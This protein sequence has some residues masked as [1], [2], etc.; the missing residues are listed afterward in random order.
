MIS[1]TAK[2]GLTAVLR[3][4]LTGVEV[5]RV[6]VDVDGNFEF[7]AS[8]TALYSLGFPNALLLE[9]V[10]ESG[11]GVSSD[12]VEVTIDATVP[13]GPILGRSLDD[14]A[15][16]GDGP[17]LETRQLR[18]GS[19]KL[20][21]NN[22]DKIEGRFD[23]ADTDPGSTVT[24]YDASDPS[25]VLGTG[26]V[27]T[28]GRFEVD[29]VPPLPHGGQAV[30][31]VSEP[32]GNSSNFDVEIDLAAPTIAVNPDDMTVDGLTGTTEAYATVTLTFA[33][34]REQT[35]TADENGVFTFTF[36]PRLGNSPTDFKL[37][38]KDRAGNES[39]E[40]TATIDPI[41]TTTPIYRQEARYK[42]VA[43]YKDVVTGWD[44]YSNG[45]FGEIYWGFYSNNGITNFF[46]PAGAAVGFTY[47]PRIEKQFSHNESVFSHYESVR[48]GETRTITGYNNE[49]EDPTTRTIDVDEAIRPEFNAVAEAEAVSE[50]A[51][52]DQPVLAEA[53]QPLPDFDAEVPAEAVSETDPV[54]ELTIESED[55]GE[56]AVVFAE[57]GEETDADAKAA[58]EGGEP[59][60]ETAADVDTTETFADTLPPAN[61]LQWVDTQEQH[62]V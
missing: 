20:W 39:G 41:V 6:P 23:I 37:T 21:W 25:K 2:P 14:T 13:V 45:L 50:G 30:L 36:S 55:K 42:T 9:V 31:N 53:E 61:S 62:L 48:I 51:E 12:P 17:Q 15:L 59:A 56:I 18:A 5:D 1:G 24:V 44:K 38:A 19:P 22:G 47:R 34:G 16:E 27:G 57:A 10:I 4:P 7:Q 35:E 40:T 11:T 29:L 60:T 3:N 8:L 33:G 52:A 54:E 26:T 49:V 28:D 46:K 32:S 43:V 58:Q